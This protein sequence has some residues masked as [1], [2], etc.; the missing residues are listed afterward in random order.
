MKITTQN[1][2]ILWSLLEKYDGYKGYDQ[3]CDALSNL[4]Q[5]K[6]ETSSLLI[7]YNYFTKLDSDDRANID[8]SIGADLEA[9]LFSI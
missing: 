1:K 5:G 3:F 4:I 7:V 2:A 8:N 9:C 6:S